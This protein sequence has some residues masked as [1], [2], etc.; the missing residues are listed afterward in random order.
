MKVSTAIA[1][2]SLTVLVGVGSALLYSGLDDSALREAPKHEVGAGGPG[3]DDSVPKDPLTRREVV[4]APYA[5]V[6]PALTPP[7]NPVPAATRRLAGAIGVFL[8]GDWSTQRVLDVASASET[9]LDELRDLWSE[10]TQGISSAR[11]RRLNLAEP[12]L[13]RLIARGFSERRDSGTRPPS[14]PGTVVFTRGRVE[15]GIR[16]EHVVR[17][18]L[19]EYPAFDR[20]HRELEA[21]NAEGRVRL[22]R[23]LHAH[24]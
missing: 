3:T 4:T 24:Q 22:A 9:N 7:T 19:G 18:A 20:A 10:V 13:D 8:G 15:A 1:A 12:I 16:E 23:F 5:P 14:I 2:V 21:A 6:D 17:I 11:S